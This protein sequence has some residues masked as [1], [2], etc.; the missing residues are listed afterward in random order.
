MNKG[1]AL[2]VTVAVLVGVAGIAA[3]GPVGTAVAQDDTGAATE[4]D[5]RNET[6]E[7]N[8]TT[9]ISPGE[10]LSGVVGVQNAEI[11]GEV[12]SRA[13]EVGLNRTT[14]DEERAA[15]VAERLN[16]SEQRLAEIERRQR[17][18]RE[19]RDAGELSQGAF[20]ARM[21]ETSARAESVERESNRSAEV[22]RGLPEQARSE[23]GLDDDRLNAVRER[24]S[25]ASGPEV[26]AIA[27]GV[28]GDDVGGPLASDRRGP[29][30]ATPGNGRDRGSAG[31]PSTNASSDE[32][33]TGT[34]AVDPDNATIG[35]GNA[36]GNGPSG[37]ESTNRSDSD[38]RSAADAR[39]GTDR[40]A[41]GSGGGADSGDSDESATATESAAGNGTTAAGNSTGADTASE[42]G[43]PS[44]SD[45]REA[46]DSNRGGADRATDAL[47]RLTF[48]EATTDWSAVTDAVG[49]TSARI[50]QGL[51]GSAGW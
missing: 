29:P 8:E 36:V 37:S 27:R 4:A 31:G 42:S 47:R 26:A 7:G 1:I 9:D 50:R 51:S 5:E 39:N 34:A 2:L 13:F 21:A 10:R 40:S 44:A 28:T 45:N 14:T 23:R 22:A 17:E 18:L 12:D 41:S 3:A 48:E 19:R 43:G 38:D 49:D 35:A 15:F 32:N 30:N 16:R 25:E 33:R 6:R 11:A 46:T 24:A 20:A